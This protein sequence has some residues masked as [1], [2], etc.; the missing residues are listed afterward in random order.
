M[1]VM[2]IV[3]SIIAVELGFLALLGAATLVVKFIYRNHDFEPYLN[4]ERT[5][6]EMYDDSKGGPS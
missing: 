3:H 2:D 4:E 1:E 5:F 6:W